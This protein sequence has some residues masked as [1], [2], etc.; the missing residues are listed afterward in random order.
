MPRF[1]GRVAILAVILLATAAAQSRVGRRAGSDRGDFDY[2]LLSLSWAPDFCALPNAPKGGAECGK[3]AHA[4]FVV[5]GLWPQ[6][7][8][9]RGPERCGSGQ[10]L[11][12][13]LVERMLAYIPSEGLI[14]H[15]WSTHGVCAGLSP[16][17]YFAMIRKARDS[18][19]IPG[20]FQ[21][22]HRQIRLSS[23]EIEA[24]FAGVNPGYPRT[25]FRATCASGALQEVRVCL[26]KDL[27]PR[28]CSASAGECRS[29]SML[30][31]PVP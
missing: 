29:G 1:A 28:A 16:I 7:E 27:N 4:G 25:A 31:R 26:S 23:S 18:L 6:L 11:S 21:N 30:I 8:T 9:G 19:K 24:E 14:R 20:D 3:D 5:H 2:Y 22:Q 17:D 12:R 15:E 10:T 13:E